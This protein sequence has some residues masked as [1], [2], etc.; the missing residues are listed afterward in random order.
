MEEK[1]VRAD[2]ATRF[3]KGNKLGKGYGRPKMSDAQKLMS[4]KSR[5]MF[6]ELLAQYMT[7]TLPEIK[8]I[9]AA[10]E[11]PA[12]D[13]AVV[14]HLEQMIETGSMERVDW[15]AD[16]IMGA[17]PKQSEVTI[18]AKRGIDTKK[19]SDAELEQLKVIAEK[20]EE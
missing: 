18:T 3:Q 14:K 15:M 4:I 16:H 10:K 1:K 17:K 8:V 2:I 11:L 12:I 7:L 5:T 13:M 20:S 19:L 9:L 6:K